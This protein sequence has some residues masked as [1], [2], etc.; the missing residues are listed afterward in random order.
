MLQS[1]NFCGPLLRSLLYWGT[2][3]QTHHSRC[4]NVTEQRRRI[5][6]LNCWQ[7][8][9]ECSSRCHLSIMLLLLLLLLLDITIIALI[10][11]YCYCNLWSEKWGLCP[12][13]WAMQNLPF[14]Q[15]FPVLKQSSKNLWNN[16]TLGCSKEDIFN[17]YACLS[18]EYIICAKR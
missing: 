18:K 2:Q 16:V 3:N 15:N 17:I 12:D 11:N 9:S 6:S 8:S 4:D 10:L 7:C 13:S 1:F 5:N 14:P